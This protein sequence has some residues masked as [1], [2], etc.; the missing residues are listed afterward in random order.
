MI[1]KRFFSERAAFRE[2][3]WLGCDGSAAARPSAVVSTVCVVHNAFR[4]IYL[5]RA[6]TPSAFSLTVYGIYLLA[7]GIGLAVAPGLPLAMLGLP[8]TEEPWIRVLGLV[9]GEVGFYIL[10]AARKNLVAFF[11]ATVYGRA[12]AAVVF[13]ALVASKL[14]PAQLL[15]FAA[16]DAVTATWTY[17]AMRRQRAA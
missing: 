8:P 3:T 4:K 9:A 12:G 11:P 2:D 13:V 16:V 14:A 7:N 15:L 17:L 5:E 10:F 1:R 6:L